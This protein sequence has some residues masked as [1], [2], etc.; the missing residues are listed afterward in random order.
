M[1]GMLISQVCLNFCFNFSQRNFNQ[2]LLAW[3]SYKYLNSGPGSIA[4]AFVHA[5]HAE[6]KNLPR[7]AAWWGHDLRTRFEMREKQFHPIAGA[8]GFRISN[9]PVVCVVSLLASLQIFDEVG[10]Q[11]LRSKSVLLTGYLEHLLKTQ[12]GKSVEI[13][14]PS[15]PTQRGCQ[16]SLIFQIDVSA[17]GKRLSENGVICDVRKPH[18]L[19]V[20]PTPLYNSFQDVFKFVEVIKL[21]LQQ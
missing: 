1:I 5:K 20:A 13:I 17:L 14:T 3:C 21:E 12:I 10:I 16:L 19:R 4:G 15:D 8:F 9:P 18:V 2:F 6:D 7:F 11:N